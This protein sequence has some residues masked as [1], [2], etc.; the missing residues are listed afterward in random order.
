VRAFA[1]AVLAAGAAA[2]AACDHD[3]VASTDSEETVYDDTISR[4]QVDSKSGNIEFAAAEGSQ[5]KVTRE[6]KWTREKP[7]SAE[8]VDDG[9]LRVELVGCESWSSTNCGISYRF[10]VPSGMEI[11]ATTAAGNITVIGLSGKL[12][13]E[14]K[15]GNVEGA[16]LTTD[17]MD[18]KTRAGNVELR[19][20]GGTEQIKAHTDA[21]NV[22][23]HFAVPP[24]NIDVGTNAG[25]VTVVVPDDG[26]MYAVNAD[27]STAD[28]D[29]QVV[30]SEDA[31]RQIKATTRA[32]NVRVDYR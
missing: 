21:G 25:N 22:D 20:V 6:F 32:G 11:E 17:E 10:E 28:P 12:D 7:A 19:F 30:V 18:A 15:A 3:G 13:L 31:E 26:T 4:I 1:I 27:S 14:T 8:V 24:V 9:T 16:G 29:V 2:L 23:V 5:V